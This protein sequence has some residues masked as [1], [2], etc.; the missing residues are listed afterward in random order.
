MQNS[1]TVS[2]SRMIAMQ[3]AVEVT[4]TNIANANTPGYKAER[5]QFADWLTPQNGTAYPR[6]G[7]TIASTTLR[8]TYRDI[9]DGTLKQTGNPLDFA[10]S[11]PGYFTVNTPRGPRLTRAG[12]FNLA[13]DGTIV[14]DEGNPLLDVNGQ[15]LQ[16]TTTDAHLSLTSNGI[17]SSDGG[18]IGQI[19][20]VAPQDL[21]QI[22]PEGGKLY[23]TQNPTNPVAQ[24]KIVQG[25]LEESNVEP[26]AELTTLLTMQ[27]QFDLAAQFTQQEYTRQMSAIDKILPPGT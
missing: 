27:R 5:M 14:D 15:Q 10:I 4:A 7:R 2:L 23:N 13:P 6:G 12:H 25:A 19:G 20:V 8:A 22:T 11:G 17:L 1:V 26:V 24:P 3:H 9:R 21:R 18:V 16:V